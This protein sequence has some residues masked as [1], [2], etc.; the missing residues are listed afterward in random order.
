[1]GGNNM[2]LFI[3]EQIT[4][5]SG[6]VKAL[7]PLQGRHGN[8]SLIIRAQDLGKPSLSV[9]DIIHICVID[10]NDHAPVF[11]SPPHNSTLRVPEVSRSKNYKHFIRHI[12]TLIR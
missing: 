9:E 7:M 1:M 11:I 12:E 4:K 5:W 8:Y 3:L 10:Y 2:E 6:E